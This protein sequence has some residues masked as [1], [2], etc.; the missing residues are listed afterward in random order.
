MLDAEGARIGGLEIVEERAA[1]G[2]RDL[3]RRAQ[4]HR[5][6]EEHEHLLSPE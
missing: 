4:H 6:E 3:Q 2:I 1:E 5:E